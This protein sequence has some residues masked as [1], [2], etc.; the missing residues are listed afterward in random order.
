MSSALSPIAILVREGSIVV[1]L[2]T[3]RWYAQSMFTLPPQNV[4]IRMV[5]EDVTFSF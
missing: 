4:V 1:N 2:G 5:Q 3:L